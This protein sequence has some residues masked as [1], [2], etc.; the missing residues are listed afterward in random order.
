[1][2]PVS[3]RKFLQRAGLI[4]CSVAASPLITPM[5]FASVP[6]DNRLVVIILRG[7]MDGLDV[8]QPYGDKA[9]FDMRKTLKFG[10]AAGAFDLDGYFSMHTGLADLI[11]LWRAGQLGFAHAVSTPYRDKR[12]HFDGQDLLEAGT[13]MD[14]PVGAAR[15]GWLNRMLQTLPDVQ[16]QTA[17]AIGQESLL[18]TTGAAPVSNWSPDT[19]FNLTDQSQRLLKLV[20]QNDPL[21]GGS[22]D[23]AISL[24]H[25]LDPAAMVDENDTDMEMM[26][27]QVMASLKGG[28]H[29]RVAEFAANRLRHATRIAA[30]S[31][32]GWDTHGGQ[33][34]AISGALTKLADTILILQR[35]L[36]PVWNKTTV[37]AMTEFGRTARENGTGGTDHGTGGALV[38]A[39]GALKGGKVFGDWPGLGQGNLYQDR[40]LLPTADVRAYAARAMQGLFG[41]DQ[42]V[43]ETAIFPS[44]DMGNTPEI[45]L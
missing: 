23:E 17:F 40:D 32:N 2:K 29:K 41:L 10:D 34:R 20:Y 36:G 33:K 35:D 39:G 1:M 37:L 42:S 3:R 44:L 26:Q 31:I 45:I 7:A 11:P 16:A 22:L 18:V 9:F 14:A 25:S 24:A 43:L 28:A 19:H 27:N 30:F 12:S 5:T 21:F 13:G 6:S 8:V 38:M 4:G 15:D